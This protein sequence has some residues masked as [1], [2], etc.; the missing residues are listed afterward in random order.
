MNNS[1]PP[2]LEVQGVHKS[3][4]ATPALRGIDLSVS[5]GEVLAV[6]GPSG[7]GKSTLLHCMAGVFTPD[8]GAITYRPDA[9]DARS[10]G[11]NELGETERSRLRIS[12]SS[13]STDNYFPSSPRWTTWRFR[14]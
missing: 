9:S 6:M 7:S 2:V 4:G 8:T 5:R 3:F 10:V 14:C 1:S 12:V 11:I 13:S